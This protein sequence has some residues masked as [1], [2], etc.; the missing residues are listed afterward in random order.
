LEF[1]ELIYIWKDKAFT[2]LEEA[3]ES[4]KRDLKFKHLRKYLTGEDM[5]NLR[6]GR[7]RLK[8][9]LEEEEK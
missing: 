6:E 2:A 8:G 7:D 1:I 4:C 9:C 5:K 3:L